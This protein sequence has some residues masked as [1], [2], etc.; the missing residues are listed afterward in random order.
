MWCETTP[1]V[2]ENLTGKCEVQFG[3]DLNACVKKPTTSHM[4]V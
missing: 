4:H 1:E 2:A 3:I